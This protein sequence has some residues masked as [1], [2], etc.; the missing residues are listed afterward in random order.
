MSEEESLRLNG[1]VC[2]TE[3]HPITEHKIFSSFESNEDDGEND[4]DVVEEN[5][6]PPSWLTTEESEHIISS[7]LRATIYSSENGLEMFTLA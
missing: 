1:N 3:G 4:N 7:I 5:D 2:T 6:I